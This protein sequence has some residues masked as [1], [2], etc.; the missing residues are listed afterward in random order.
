MKATFKTPEEIS[1]ALDIY[2][3]S[4]DAPDAARKLGCRTMTI[5]RLAKKH[6]I[7]SHGKSGPKNLI[8]FREDYFEAI[9]T[10]E[11]AYWLGFIAADGCVRKGRGGAWSFAMTLATKDKDHLIKLAEALGLTAASVR[12]SLT[13]KHPKCSLVLVRKSFAFHL[14]DKGIVQ[15]KTY[16]GLDFPTYLTQDLMR[17]YLRGY[18]DGD[19]CWYHHRKNLVCSFIS[20]RPEFLIAMRDYLTTE[21][22]VEPVRVCETNDCYRMVWEGRAQCQALFNF[23]YHDAIVYLERKK[24]KAEDGLVLQPIDKRRRSSKSHSKLK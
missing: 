20:K 2:K 14:I 1:H 17:D 4:I 16:V 8:P 19:G 10:S 7:P 22:G 21:C 6:G 11:K 13:G 9:D 3:N 24:I 15:N 5:W 12:D 18:L 23:F